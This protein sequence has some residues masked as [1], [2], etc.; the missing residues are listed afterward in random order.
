MD[1]TG[2]GEPVFVR[3]DGDDPPMFS[4]AE[5]GWTPRCTGTPGPLLWA[6]IWHWLRAHWEWGPGLPERDHQ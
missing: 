3:V 1:R 6:V 5:C 4:C 2:V